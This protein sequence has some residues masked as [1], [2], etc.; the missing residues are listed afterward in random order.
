[1]A[2]RS[3]VQP[4][5]RRCAKPIKKSIVTHYFGQ[6]GID[7]DGIRHH[8][9]AVFT[10]AEAKRYLNDQ[11]VSVRYGYQGSIIVGTW[12]GESY[13]DEFFC[14]QRC[15]VEFAYAAVRHQSGLA[16]PAYHEAIAKRD[17]TRYQSSLPTSHS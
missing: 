2:F 15:A 4:L 5:C 11:I 3:Q 13:V 17:L 1:M 16:M 7:S 9:E 14:V 12:D 6:G 10:K 8:H